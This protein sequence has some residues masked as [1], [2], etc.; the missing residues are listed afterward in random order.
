MPRAAAKSSWPWPAKLRPPTAAPCPV[1][2]SGS[3]TGFFTQPRMGRIQQVGRAQTAA[4]CGRQ[5]QAVEREHFPKVFPQALR[6]RLSFAFQPPGQ[7]FESDLA[8]LGVQ[9]ASLRVAPWRLKIRPHRRPGLIVLF[10]G[11][12][13][14]DVAYLV[15]AATRH[16]SI[17]AKHRINP[18]PQ[19]LTPVDNQPPSNRG[20]QS[21]PQQVVQY[22]LNHRGVF[23]YPWRQ[24]RYVLIALRIHAQS[25]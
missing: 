18:G 11:Q 20:I 3:H 25:A 9:L 2:F 14:Q 10:F 13:G 24:T 22:V 12:M 23:R 4:Q 21:P 16:R 7:W 6:R 17:C 1:L 8:G 5:A 15:L 19:R